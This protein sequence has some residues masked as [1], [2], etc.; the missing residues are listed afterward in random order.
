MVGQGQASS[1]EVAREDLKGSNFE[2][3]GE[4]CSRQRE[5]AKAKPLGLAFA[6][7]ERRRVCLELW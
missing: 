1:N 6:G 2:E 4:E 3:L 7:K 5:L